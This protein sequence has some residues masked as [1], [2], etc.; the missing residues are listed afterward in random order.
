[1]VSDGSYGQGWNGVGA[2]DYLGV[3]GRG[4]TGLFYGDSKQLVA[5]LVEVLVGVV[6]NVAVGGAAF[7][8]IGKLV[9]NRVPA[10]VEIRGLDIPEMGAEGYPEF[11]R[12]EEEEL[13]PAIAAKAI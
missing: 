8:I 9:G 4:V 12:P 1:L 11:Q 7:L 10:D 2:T 6:W 13:V 5:Q 3:A